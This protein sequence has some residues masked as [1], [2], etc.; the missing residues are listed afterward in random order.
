MALLDLAAE[1][2]RIWGK[3]LQTAGITADDMAFCLGI[4]NAQMLCILSGENPLGPELE[5]IIRETLNELERQRRE[6]SRNSRRAL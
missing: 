2:A 1:K 5:L 3:R 4:T 6:E